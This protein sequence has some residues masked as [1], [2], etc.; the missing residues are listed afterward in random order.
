MRC[1]LLAYSVEEPHS[2]FSQSEF[3]GLSHYLTSLRRSECVL[4]VAFFN[5]TESPT[6][7]MGFQQNRPEA[8][9]VPIVKIVIAL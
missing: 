4:E 9:V 2:R 3:G 1:P 5:D 6:L 7:Q 8:D